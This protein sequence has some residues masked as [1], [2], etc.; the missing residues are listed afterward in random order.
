MKAITA[1]VT[2]I[3]ESWETVSRCFVTARFQQI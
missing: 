1:A 3:N 2:E